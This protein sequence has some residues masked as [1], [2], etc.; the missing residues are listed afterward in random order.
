MRSD[1]DSAISDSHY[2]I[3]ALRLEGDPNLTAGL[4]ELA[5][6][7]QEVAEYLGEPVG[8][9]LE[10]DRLGEREDRHAASRR[11]EAGPACLDRLFQEP[12]QLQ[13]LRLELELIAGQPVDI[14]QVVD[15]AGHVG[16]LSFHHGENRFE[17]VHTRIAPFQ[18]LRAVNHRTQQVAK[19]MGQGR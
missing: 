11:F 4:G 2:H 9:S 18:N 14:Q 1:S 12:A 15:Q 7:G 16:H 6:I 19:L 5:R 10:V 13:A 8:V 17:Q 3:A